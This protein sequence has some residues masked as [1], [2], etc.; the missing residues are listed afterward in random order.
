MSEK[1]SHV[2]QEKEAVSEHY[3]TDPRVFQFFLD[4][5]MNYSAAYFPEGVEDL[6]AAQEK[7]LDLIAQKIDLRPEDELLDV[8]CGWGNAL[9]YYAEKYGCQATGLTL[10]GNQAAVIE[11]KAEEAGLDGQVSVVVEHF[12]EVAFPPERFDKVIF[13]GSII[14]IEDRA[15]AAR[16]TASLLRDGGKALISET[17][18]PKEPQEEASR[19]SKF[20]S[21]GIFGYSNLITPGQEIRFLE[22]AGFELLDVE[23][24]TDHYI[25]T[26][27]IWIDRVKANKEEIEAVVPGESKRLRTYLTLARRSLRRR[28]SLQQ[29]ILVQ[30]IPG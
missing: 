26:L 22:E 30:K 16:L 4:E 23:N 11:E 2:Q 10:A 12:Q 7:K 27:N 18:F 8:G 25:K 13:I 28:T 19:A 14:H 21:Q 17:Y 9:L 24:I 20:I 5:K 3:D 15:E 6:D 29:Q 1:V